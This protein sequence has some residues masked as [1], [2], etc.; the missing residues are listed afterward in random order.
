MQWYNILQS[1]L[2]EDQGWLSSAPLDIDY[3]NNNRVLA[4]ALNIDNQSSDNNV[5]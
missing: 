4:I 1:M 2:E 5:P 3:D